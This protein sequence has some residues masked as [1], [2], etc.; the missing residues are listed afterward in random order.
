MSNFFLKCKHKLK[1]ILPKSIFNII[2]RLFRIIKEPFFYL[3]IN[4]LFR[5]RQCVDIE[6]KNIKFKMILDPKNGFLD[7]YIYFYK[8]DEPKILDVFLR[9]I[10]Q[11]DI[12]L[13][14][15]MNNGHHTLFISKIIGETGK[16]YSF[17]PI[18]RLV[19]QVEESVKINGID[20]IKINN[21]ALGNKEIESL[22]NIEENNLACAS[23][24]EA[25]ENNSILEKEKIII[26]K[27]DS[28]DLPKIDFI[29]IDTEGY[30]WEVIKGANSLIEKDK[31][32]MVFEFNPMSYNLEDKNA[33]YN[34]L[35]YLYNLGYR[36]YDINKS[37]ILISDLYKFVDTFKKNTTNQQTNILAIMD[38]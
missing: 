8:I 1:S 29:K 23:I 6:Y 32:I 33:S 17:E 14:I 35:E 21:F 7:K 24:L 30:E 10:K 4:F 9:Y 15:G 38:K 25:E 28:L 19:S 26:K 27:I 20:N 2:L 3:K 13:D 31:P 34:F 5:S 37:L 18:K 16:I 12:V 11:G 22:I 36:L